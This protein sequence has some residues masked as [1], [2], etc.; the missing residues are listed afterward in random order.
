MVITSFSRCPDLQDNNF[1]LLHSAISLDKADLG[2]A[3]TIKAR[4]TRNDSGFINYSNTI[5]FSIKW[6]DNSGYLITQW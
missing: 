6:L 4:H 2:C 5:K 3:V 1:D